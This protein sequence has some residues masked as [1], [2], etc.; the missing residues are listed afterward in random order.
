MV[1]SIEVRCMLLF[2]WW[3]CSCGCRVVSLEVRGMPLHGVVVS[4]QV[5]GTLLHGVAALLLPL[6]PAWLP[7]GLRRGSGLTGEE[8]FRKK[9]KLIL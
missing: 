7:S 2:V 9:N 3:C 1:V 5:R 8:T 6:H 4:L